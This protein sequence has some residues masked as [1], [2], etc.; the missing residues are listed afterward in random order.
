[1]LRVQFVAIFD[2]PLLCLSNIVSSHKVWI[3]AIS[4]QWWVTFSE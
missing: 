1:M 2:K 4:T 3:S